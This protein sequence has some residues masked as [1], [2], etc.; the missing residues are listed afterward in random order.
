MSQMMFNSMNIELT[1][2]CPLKCPQ[3]YCSLTGDKHIDL[4]LAK[5]KIDEAVKHGVKNISMSGGE[6]LCYPWLYELISYASKRCERVNIAISGCFFDKNVLK[7]LLLSGVT[8]ISVSLNGSTE[9][10]NQ[11][12]RDGYSLAMNAIRIIGEAKVPN[13]L[14][15]WVMHSNNCE[16]FSNI[17]AIAEK[18]CISGID[19]IMF[20]PDSSHQLNSYPSGQQMKQIA[21]FVRHYRGSVKILVETCFSQMLALIFNESWIGNIDI[22]ENKGCRAGQYLYN[23]SVDGLYSPCRH[24][25]QF[26]KFDTLEQYI[27]NSPIIHKLSEYENDLRSPC[28]T[29][30]LNQY[31]RPCPAVSAQLHGEFFK[32]QES[33]QVW[34]IA[35]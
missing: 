34:Q 24:I 23:I 12:T 32:G 31:C 35:R 4:D 18:Y 6:T 21:D 25:E 29:C 5:E 11:L 9:E 3:C 2:K 17:V 10:I 22:G 19:I 14:I 26:E 1:N 8:S 7:K 33:C 27:S 13:S 28:S 15:N 16:D 30:R 20:K